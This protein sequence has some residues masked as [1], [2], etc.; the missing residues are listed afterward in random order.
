MLALLLT[1]TLRHRREKLDGYEHGRA[2]KCPLT[3]AELEAAQKGE[4]RDEI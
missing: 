1:T 4:S 3:H 2:A